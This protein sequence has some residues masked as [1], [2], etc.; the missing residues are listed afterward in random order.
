MYQ[1]Y[2]SKKRPK[3]F[4][5]YHLKSGLERA[6]R[7]S[8]TGTSLLAHKLPLPSATISHLLPFPLPLSNPLIPPPHSIRLLNTSTSYNATYLTANFSSTPDSITS[9]STLTSLFLLH[10]SFP[11]THPTPPIFPF[12]PLPITCIMGDLRMFSRSRGIFWNE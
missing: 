1:V 4:Y 2:D 5:E 9:T 3:S 12:I 8:R 7:R 10:L 6:G 11:S